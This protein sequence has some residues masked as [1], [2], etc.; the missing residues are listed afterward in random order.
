MVRFAFFL[1][2]GLSFIL[3]SC[4]KCTRCSFTYEVTTIVQTVNGE[5]EQ[6]STQSGVL[7]G[8]D[9]ESFSEECIKS[10]ESLTIEQW[11]QGKAD[12]TALTNFL[13]TCIEQ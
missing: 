13:H 7:A 2:L 11:Y 4:E 8:P 3:N 6:I 5:V 1:L 10:G 12:T 9:G